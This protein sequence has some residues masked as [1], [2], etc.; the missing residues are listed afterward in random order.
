M[1]K[2]C[3]LCTSQRPPACCHSIYTTAISNYSVLTGTRM[4][5]FVILCLH[6]RLLEILH[7]GKK[8]FLKWCFSIVHLHFKSQMLDRYLYLRNKSWAFWRGVD[9]DFEPPPLSMYLRLVSCLVIII[10]RYLM[11]VGWVR[12]FVSK[13]LWL[14]FYSY[15]FWASVLFSWILTL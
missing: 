8:R 9:I 1:Q 3:T 6:S 4:L 5:L 11:V 15:C 7:V 2:S 13:S 12:Q 14:H 10:K